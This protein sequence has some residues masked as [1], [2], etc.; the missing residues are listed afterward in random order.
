MFI[1]FFPDFRVMTEK[2]LYLQ[3]E[4]YSGAYMI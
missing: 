3:V 2:Q 4:E 1:C